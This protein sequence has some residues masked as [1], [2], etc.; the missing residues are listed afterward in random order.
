MPVRSKGLRSKTRYLLL[1]DPRHRGVLPPNRVL[2]QFE[3]GS[4]V[5]VKMEPSQHAGM[6]HKR[7]QGQTGT[8][9]GKQG[10]AFVVKILHGNKPKTLLVRAEHL[11]PI[12]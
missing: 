2:R 10:E 5:A 11:I 1:K 12:K 6:T 4:R 9:A 8:V 7:F 3:V